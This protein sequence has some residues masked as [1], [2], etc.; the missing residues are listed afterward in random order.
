MPP[1]G[2]AL[3]PPSKATSLRSFPPE[4]C[5]LLAGPSHLGDKQDALQEHV[6][7]VI[8]IHGL[9]IHKVPGLQVRVIWEQQRAPGFR[10][11]RSH[12]QGTSA[13]AVY[14]RPR[15]AVLPARVPSTQD[16]ED[17]TVGLVHAYILV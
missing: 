4:A 10:T 16:L 9:L 5:G 6:I 7:L 14:T 12:H 1:V 8:L 17:T 3:A 13:H 2:T 11:G 15:A